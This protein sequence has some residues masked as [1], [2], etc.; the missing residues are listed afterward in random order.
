MVPCITWHSGR[1]GGSRGRSLFSALTQHVW[2]FCRLG[3]RAIAEL[4]GIVAIVASLI[5]V[6]RQ[7]QQEQEIA[8]AD[9]HTSV[10]SNVATLVAAAPEIWK[11]GLDGEELSAK[12]EIQFLAIV[13]AVE[14][15]MFNMYLRFFRLGIGDPATFAR[16]YAF[17]M[18]VHRGLRRKVSKTLAYRDARDAA[19]SEDR[20]LQTFDDLVASQLQHLDRT[21]PAIPAEKQ[22]VFWSGS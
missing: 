19:F 5:F 6:G 18:Y 4:I 7:I 9:T 3:R 17:A 20:A 10:A 15:H 21:L 13:V 14:A 22:Y 2:H 1:I 11:K 12:D 16:D 8:I